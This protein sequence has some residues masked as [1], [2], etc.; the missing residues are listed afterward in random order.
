MA[1]YLSDC[2]NLF[3]FFVPSCLFIHAEACMFIHVHVASWHYAN[4]SVQYTAISHNCK[5]G[6]F[7]MK[8]VIF[9]LYQYPLSM[10]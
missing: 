2:I 7:P 3:F 1:L 8:N 10:F 4:M 9:I 6:N 5:N